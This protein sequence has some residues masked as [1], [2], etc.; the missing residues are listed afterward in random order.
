MGLLSGL[1]RGRPPLP[2]LSGLPAHHPPS[3]AIQQQPD[4]EPGDQRIPG[5]P[6]DPPETGSLVSAG[7]RLSRGCPGADG[8]LVGQPGLP[9]LGRS[10]RQAGPGRAVRL[11]SRRLEGPRRGPGLLHL[12]GAPLCWRAGRF[13]LGLP[14]PHGPDSRRDR[15]GQG[16]EPVGG[17]DRRSTALEPG[18]PALRAGRG[19]QGVSA[20]RSRGQLGRASLLH[21]PGAHRSRGPGGDLDLLRGVRRAAPFQTAGRAATRPDR[22]GHP[23][24]GRVRQHHR[25]RV[26]DH[27]APRFPG[28]PPP[29]Q[30]HR[31]GPVRW[32]TATGRSR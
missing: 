5:L 4:L 7:A 23:S 21:R 25:R 14:Q 1:L 9:G 17:P 24:S 6:P 10:Q 26:V 28:Q 27:A 13:H 32:E 29:H 3:T 12:G 2:A 30:R 8:G 16:P 11:F 18:R 19:P 31:P 15:F 20:Q 22:P